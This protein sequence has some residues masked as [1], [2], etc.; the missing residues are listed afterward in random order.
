MGYCQ[1]FDYTSEKEGKQMRKNKLIFYDFEVF[2]KA[3]NPETGECFWMVVLIDYDTGKKAVIINDREKLKQ[4]YDLLKNEIWIGY[5]SRQYDQYILKSLLL[6][7]NV[8]HINDKI[9]S[10][11]KGWQLVKDAWKVQLY[12]FD[13][14]VLMESLKKIEGFMGSKIKETSVNFELDRWLTDVEI[15]EVAEYCIHD[16]RETIKVYEETKEELDSYFSMIELFNLDLSYL[17]K[18]KAQLAAKVLGAEKHESRGDEFNYTLPQNLVLSEKYKHVEEWFLNENNHDYKKKLVTEIAGTEATFAWGGLHSALKKYKHE[19]IILCADVASLYPALMINHD[20]MS[21]NVSDRSKYREIRDKRLELKKVKDPRQ[22][23]LKIVL[24]STYGALKDQYNPLYDPLQSTTV[25][26]YGQL[27]LLDLIDK[28]EQSGVGTLIQ[29]N[30]DGVF[31]KVDNMDEV[32]KIKEICVDWEKRSNLDLEY[33]IAN[34]VFQK[35]VNNYVLV[36]EDGKYKSKGSY[37]KKL[38][39]ID[40]DLPIVNKALIDFFTKGVEIEETINNC[41]TL[42]EFQKIV[43]V[44]RLYKHALHGDKKLPEKV[45]RVFAS[46]EEDA[47]GVFKVKWKMKDGVEQD[48]AEKIGNTPEKCFIDN[49]NVK[50]KLVPD[51]LDKEYYIEVARKRLNDFLGIPNKKK[52]SE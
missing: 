48:V 35:D 18:T 25:C 16:V 36:F 23:P 50:D 7:Y 20:L 19:G 5:S 11:S 40:Y 1:N 47:Q 4:A 32:E 29:S 26:V 12:N 9:I 31:W 41:N 6:N 21:R 33:E 27:W 44:S 42:R 13:V 49:D 10:G 22:Q 17:N 34:K 15:E 38:S 14:Q 46:N 2:S 45:L 37:V 51:H 39:N 8:G 24:N 43:K 52:K 3:I 30:T 28:V